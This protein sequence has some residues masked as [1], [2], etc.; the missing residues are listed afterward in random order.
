MSQQRWS[1]VVGNLA[2]CIG[3]V[4]CSVQLLSCLS[5][6]A[7]KHETVAAVYD[8]SVGAAERS[9]RQIVLQDCSSPCSVE[10]FQN[11]GSELAV[12]D[13]RIARCANARILVFA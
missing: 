11:Q 6:H 2:C 4:F 13:V 3:K 1:S 7:S 5:G 8:P 9:L 10:T 12:F